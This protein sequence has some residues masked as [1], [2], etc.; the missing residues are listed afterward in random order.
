MEV[1]NQ[2]AKANRIARQKGID[3][4]I[5]MSE[6]KDKRFKAVYND[7]DKTTIHFGD[8]NATPYFDVKDEKKRNAYRARA[9][10]IRNKE[11][12]LT[13]KIPKTANHLAYSILW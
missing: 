8:P 13:Y 2:L 11:G 3:A 6:R 7:K 9:S 4:K 5:Y 12:R 1:H 10:K